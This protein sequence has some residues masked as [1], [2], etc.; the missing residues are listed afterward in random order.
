MQQTADALRIRSSLSGAY[1]IRVETME[2]GARGTVAETW[3]VT[4]PQGAFFVKAVPV[5]RHSALLEHSVP[6]QQRLWDAGYTQMNRPIP[7]SSGALT[8]ALEPHI[9]VVYELVD[10]VSTH[11]YPLEP[12]VDLLSALHG[13]SVPVG[14]QIETFGVDTTA[15]VE[16]VIAAALADRDPD[17]LLVGVRETLDRLGPSLER[18]IAAARR[19]RASLEHRRDLSMVITHNDAPGNVMVS[20]DGRLVLV[21]WDELL[22]APRERD[23][24]P[25]LI[26]TDRAHWFLT[27]YRRT[28]PTYEPEPDAV[29]HYLL[30]WYFE[31]I[32]GFVGPLLEPDTP[33]ESRARYGRWFAAAVPPLHD[34]LRRLERGDQPWLEE[35]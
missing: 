13:T 10:G 35:G 23:T 27:R 30:K 14:D 29:S 6:I 24:W 33:P 20:T 5:G 9:L 4:S 12:Y 2:P 1:G 17:P 25:H 32:E 8:V 21:D 3:V 19:I 15:L 31:E 7:T 26:S 22:L 18:D 34:A 11:D 16:P 28:V